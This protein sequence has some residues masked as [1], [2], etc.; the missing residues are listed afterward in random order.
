MGDYMA[1]FKFQSTKKKITIEGVDYEFDIGNKAQL[2]LWLSKIAAF[3]VASKSIDQT[4]TDAFVDSLEVMA[5]D[6]IN[7]T[8]GDWDRLWALSGENVFGMIALVG[9]LAKEFR[10]GLESATKGYGL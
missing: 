5:R 6:V 1:E 9:A 7:S 3:E 4:D 8:I 10:S 2:K